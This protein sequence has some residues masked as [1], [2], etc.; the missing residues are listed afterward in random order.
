MEG[1]EAGNGAAE[2]DEAL[3]LW[4]AVR[5]RALQNTNRSATDIISPWLIRRAGG[6]VPL[7]S[8]INQISLEVSDAEGDRRG[9]V[10][11]VV[12][13]LLRLGEDIIEDAFH[14][15]VGDVDKGELAGPGR[16]QG[17]DL[18]GFGGSADAGGYEVASLGNSQGQ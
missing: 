4:P 13:G 5:V 1:I 17:E 3:K 16:V 12:E 9:R 7:N 2:E 14:G 10:D 8:R 18:L 15:H 11:H 6:R